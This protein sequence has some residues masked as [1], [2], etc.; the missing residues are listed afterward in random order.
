MAPHLPHGASVHA[1]S[2]TKAKDSGTLRG[3]LDPEEGMEVPGTP[4]PGRRPGS[5][6]G[7]NL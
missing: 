4:T 6:P 3:P 1:T 2:T 7:T 5:T